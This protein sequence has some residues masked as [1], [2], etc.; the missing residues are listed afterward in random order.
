MSQTARYF[1][2]PSGGPAPGLLIWLGDGK[3]ET[4]EA[5]AADWQRT[6]VRDRLTLLMPEPGDAGGWTNDDLEYLARLLQ[7]AGSRWRIDP[8]RIVI[9]GEGKGGQLAYALGLRG[10]KMIRGVAVVDSPLP[11]TLVVPENNPNERLAI[12]SV[13]TQNTPLS[14]LIRQDLKK[15][16]TA[17][18]PV[19]QLV[20]RGEESRASTLDAATRAKI[21]RW[22]DGLDR[23]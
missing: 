19:T 3:R 2:P 23:L 17:G 20:R 1:Q 7:T 5:M 10:R 8:N 18:Y 14:L 16:E 21:A 6:C 9:A 4:A 11:R 13:E 15:L 12:L 22:I